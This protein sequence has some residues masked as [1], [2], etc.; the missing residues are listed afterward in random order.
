MFSFIYMLNYLCCLFDVF[1][2]IIFLISGVT[3]SKFKHYLFLEIADTLCY[4]LVGTSEQT[5]NVVEV[6][7]LAM[8]NI[9]HIYSLEICL[10]ISL[11]YQ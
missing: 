3:S 1:V 2:L 7:I 9:L 5:E 6:G 8:I 10:K 4:L 11:E